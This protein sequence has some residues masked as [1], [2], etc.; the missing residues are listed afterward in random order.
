MCCGV[1]WCGVVWCGVVWCGV[2][3]CGVVW[4]GVV[5]CGVVWC[6]VAWCAEGTVTKRQWPGCSCILVMQAGRAVCVDAHCVLCV[7]HLCGG[8]THP[9]VWQAQFMA[10]LGTPCRSACW[11]SCS[12]R[13][14]HAMV[15]PG[16][17]WAF[18]SPSHALAWVSQTFCDSDGIC[19]MNSVPMSYGPVSPI[20][21][22][23]R[24]GVAIAA[25]HCSRTVQSHSWPCTCEARGPT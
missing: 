19:R 1:V 14:A 23:R 15:P 22:A 25:D 11:C 24:D 9:H 16:P 10:T 21:A 5:W 3:W 4:C 18:I 7:A 13:R 2:V 8:Q 17:A 20:W 12:S 6:G